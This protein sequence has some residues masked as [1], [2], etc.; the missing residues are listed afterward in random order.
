MK[1]CKPDA[2][3]KI[4]GERLL[5][6]TTGGPSTNPSSRICN[7]GEYPPVFLNV[8]VVSI[9]SMVFGSKHPVSQ[10]FVSDVGISVTSL[11]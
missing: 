9:I 8:F 3:L 10:Q 5:L 7:K 11:Q 6:I 4:C 1:S 2:V